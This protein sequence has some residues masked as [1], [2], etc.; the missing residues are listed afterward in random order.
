M[1]AKPIQHF[2]I[3]IRFEMSCIVKKG[4][5]AQQVLSLIKIQHLNAQLVHNLRLELVT[6]E[7]LMN[8][9]L[10]CRICVEID[11]DDY[12]APV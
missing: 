8:R 7:K 12:S 1:I 9:V 6:R 4:P 10:F 5:V 2:A 11:V 3:G